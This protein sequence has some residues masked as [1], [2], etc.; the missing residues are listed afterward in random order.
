MNIRLLP[1]VVA[2]R[3]TAG[4]VIERP[5]AV[6]E[7]VENASDAGA[8]HIEIVLHEG[9]PAPAA[10]AATD[11]FQPDLVAGSSL[12]IHDDGGAATRSR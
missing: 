9:A 5:A 7:L 10:L 4:E 8:R 1:P 6:K 11:A 3:I 12:S 2:N